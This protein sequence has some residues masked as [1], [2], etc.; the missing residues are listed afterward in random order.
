MRKINMEQ[1][2]RRSP[3]PPPQTPSTKRAQ[4]EKPQT[5]P[6]GQTSYFNMN[7][8]DSK[9]PRIYAEITEQS[10]NEFHSAVVRNDLTAINSMI[11]EYGPI[12]INQADDNGS[13]PLYI[14]SENGCIDVVK[15]LLG[16]RYI[17]VNRADNDDSTPIE[18]L[19]SYC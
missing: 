13:T 10:I 3:T 9:R 15:L 8:V 18:K 11:E 17:D 4:E 14:A 16:Q 12:I 6:G 1:T 2:N 19:W 5:T 7:G